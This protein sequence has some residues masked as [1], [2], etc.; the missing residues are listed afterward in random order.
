MTA[1]PRTWPIIIGG[2]YRCGTTLVRRLL[3]SH[4]RIHCPP[5]VKFFKDFYGDYLADA[6]AN[7]RFFKTVRSMGIEERDLLLLFGR[8][9]VSA[10]EKAV[11]R[12][13]KARWADKDP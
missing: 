7:V 2:F 9:F 5:E 6:L 13:G 1:D 12:Q 11:Q 10:H 8:A 4:S 3:D